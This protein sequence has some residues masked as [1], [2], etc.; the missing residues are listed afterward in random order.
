MAPKKDTLLDWYRQMVLIRRFEERCAE[1][2]QQGLIGGFLHL[3]IGQEATGVGAVNALREQDHAITAYRDHGL[4]LARGLDPKA[5]MAEMLGKKTGVSG[6]KGGSMHLADYDRRFWGGYGIVGGHLPLAAGIALKAKYNEEDEVVL[7]FMG[8]GS[9]NIGYFHE[10]LNLSAVW[11]LPVVWLVENN[12]YGMGTS[13]ERASG[14]VEIVNKARA[15]CCG[16]NGRGMKEGPRVD[17][18]DVLAVYDAVS[19]GIEHAR[20]HGPILMESLTYRLEGHSMGDPQRY[21]TKEEV[22]QFVANGPIGRFR[23]YLNEKYKGIDP[24]LDT[25]DQDVLDTIDDAVEFA[26]NSPDP[27]YDDLISHVYAD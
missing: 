1:L 13:V 15:Y 18:M 23:D 8:D 7:A 2:Y 12:Q 11:E 6:G 9:T 25:I 17:G 19:E 10:A 14:A 5:V 3:Y 4:A 16:P 27:T 26:K 22:E 24:R 20:K 21:R